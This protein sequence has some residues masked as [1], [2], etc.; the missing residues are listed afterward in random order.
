V[1]DGGT[2]NWPRVAVVG[3]GY[4]GRNLVRN[5][6][7]LGALGALVDSSEER[8]RELSA[9]HGGRPATFE[10]VLSDE[11]IGAVA[12]ATPG[13]AHF[14]QAMAALEA[15]KHVYVEKPL[16]LSV[17]DSEKLVARADAWGLTLMV[18]HILRHHA[19]FVTL[20]RLIAAGRIGRLRHVVSNRLN[21]GKILADED[22]L[23]ALGPHDL[24]M[25]AAL[26]GDEPERVN[27]LADCFFRPNVADVATLRLTYADGVSAEIRLSWIAPFK[28]HKLTVWGESGVLIFDDAKPWEEKLVLRRLGLDWRNPPVTPDP[29]TLE[30]VPVPSDE[31]LKAECRNFLD[32]VAG[33]A[34]PVTDGRE[35]LAITRLL[36]R[37]A[38]SMRGGG[39]A[40]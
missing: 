17:A 3:C 40:R 20:E 9:R 5:F 39:A 38:A 1:A 4:W 30:I 35:G 25:V 10:E 31:P 8:M 22:V 16:T 12:V 32:S 14:T 6:A 37:A 13:A 34:R 11:T 2:R 27:C 29:G 26:L 19:A 36:E 23:W 7:E 28:E 15:G 18:G 24:S 33:L 21:L